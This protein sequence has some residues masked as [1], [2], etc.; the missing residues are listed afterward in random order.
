VSERRKLPALSRVLVLEAEV[1]A[2]A[3]AKEVE[4]QPNEPWDAS[5]TCEE[6]LPYSASK[7]AVPD[8]RKFYIDDGFVYDDCDNHKDSEEDRQYDGLK[9]MEYAIVAFCKYFR[10]FV[11]GN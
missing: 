7:A 4:K 11:F 5:Q 3:E 1:N 8:D 2:Y 10:N 6:K 9:S